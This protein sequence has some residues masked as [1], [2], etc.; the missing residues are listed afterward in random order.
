LEFVLFAVEE[1][2][3]PL[4][5]TEVR[6]LTILTEL[7]FV[8]SFEERVKIFHKLVSQDK[9]E[10]QGVSM[11]MGGPHIDIQARRNFLYEDAFERLSPENG[12]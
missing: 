8:V 7:P 4:S 1:E 10:H 6:K 3:P 5:T 2:G 12:E 9:T 11:Y